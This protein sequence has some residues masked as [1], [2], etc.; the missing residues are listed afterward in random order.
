MADFPASTF[1]PRTKANKAGVVFDADKHTVLFAEDVSY[2]DAEVVAIE[3][4]LGTNPKGAWADVK[5]QLV[6]LTKAAIVFIIDGAGAAIT[7]G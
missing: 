7:T 4:E 6:A 3:T 5:T 1:A 2:L